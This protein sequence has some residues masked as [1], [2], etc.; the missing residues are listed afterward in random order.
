MNNLG[1]YNTALYPWEFTLRW[2]KA[3]IFYDIL[4]VW[5]GGLWLCSNAVVIKMGAAWTNGTNGPICTHLRAREVLEM[6]EFENH[7]SNACQTMCWNKNRCCFNRGHYVLQRDW[8]SCDDT[9]FTYW[10]E[11]AALYGS[12]GW[13]V[14][15]VSTTKNHSHQN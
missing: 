8:H 1:Y 12:S 9:L 11:C 13:R 3:D 4:N 15:A 6:K 2:E 7:C 14:T 10:P 5:L